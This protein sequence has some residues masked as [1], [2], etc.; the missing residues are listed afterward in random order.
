MDISLFFS[1]NSIIR[2]ILHMLDSK[3]FNIR[4][5]EDEKWKKLKF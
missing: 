3:I 5:R 2:H 1:N 4:K